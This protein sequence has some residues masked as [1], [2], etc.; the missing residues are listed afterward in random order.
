MS[1]HFVSPRLVFGLTPCHCQDAQRCF[2]GCCPHSCCPAIVVSCGSYSFTHSCRG[3]I[4]GVSFNTL[5]GL[6]SSKVKGASHVLWVQ[7]HCVALPVGLMLCPS[8]H[9]PSWACCHSWLL[10]GFV[11]QVSLCCGCG[12]VVCSPGC[13]QDM[14]SYSLH[15][16]RLMSCHRVI[17]SCWSFSSCCRIASQHVVCYFLSRSLHVSC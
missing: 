8:F 5:T 14:S 3:G 12:Y 2:F 15:L 1:L 16:H 13:G 10:S 9:S 6:L 17:S 4:A 7:S 11:S